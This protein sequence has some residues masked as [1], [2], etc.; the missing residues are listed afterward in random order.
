M[1]TS[2]AGMLPI[3]LSNYFYK[4]AESEHA[5]T[6]DKVMAFFLFFGGGVLMCTIFLHLL[7]E[8]TDSVENLE[9]KNV[10]KKFPLAFPELILCLGFFIMFL[11]EEILHLCFSRSSHKNNV[12]DAST[13][14]KAVFMVEKSDNKCSK[15]VNDKGHTTCTEHE[16]INNVFDGNKNYHSCTE[17]SCRIIEHGMR[18]HSIEN[19]INHDH[20]HSHSHLPHKNKSVFYGL[21][22]VLALSVHEIFEGLAVGLEPKEP[23]VW[24]M[25]TAVTCHEM[26]LAGFIGIQ[27][28]VTNVKHSISY[29]YVAAFALTSPTGIMIGLYMSTKSPTD[30][31]LAVVSVTLQAMATGTLM[32]ILFFEVYGK[33]FGKYKMPGI[34]K[35]LASIIGFV[36]MSILQMELST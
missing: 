18:H 14:D 26:V 31:T 29:I 35:V 3:K 13:I 2:L 8:V 20:E 21:L 16:H 23:M 27:L 28:V 7:P 19:S 36:L 9:A 22:T 24:Y 4:S 10:L 11:V 25:L 17:H 33:Q 30:Q 32:Y 1:T 34:M 12:P 6:F 15:P 5:T